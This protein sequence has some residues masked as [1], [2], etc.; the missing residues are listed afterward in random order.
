[1]YDLLNLSID[2]Q[3]ISIDTTEYD[4]GMLINSIGD[5][6]NTDQLAWIYFVNGQAGDVAA[7]K[8]SI[9]NGDIVEWKY[10]KPSF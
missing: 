9:T 7:D 1:V 8:K 2:E 4:F 6:T 10:I 5:K 3:G